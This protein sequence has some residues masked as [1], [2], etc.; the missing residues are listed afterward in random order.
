M[1]N[2]LKNHDNLSPAI[3]ANSLLIIVSLLSTPAMACELPA[4]HASYSIKKYGSTIA[5]LNMSLQAD[6]GLAQY[7]LHTEAVGLLA[8][9]SDE[10]L[11]E[12]SHLKQA[13]NKSWSLE[14][15]SQHRAT[16][17]TRY[18]K[19][20]LTPNND[21]LQAQ[22]E[23]NGKSFSL[24]PAAPAWDRSSVQLALTCDLLAD[25]KPRSA[26]D[27]TVIDKGEI[28]TY[29]FEYRGQENIRI[30]DK[31]I[32]TL[33]FER[34]SGDRSTLFWLAPAM[35]YMLVRMEQYK[36]DSLHLRMILDIPATEKP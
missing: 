22:G 4:W 13:E 20:S 8:A 21:S 31:Q 34:I 18:Q 5:R 19:F 30:A 1:A 23:N 11:T 24:K 12:T 16:N 33:K 3:F 26:Y 15:F 17:K 25:N 32:D 7:N 28:T 6:N 9:I 10:E 14:R 29:H 2:D 35:R 36:K 27:Y